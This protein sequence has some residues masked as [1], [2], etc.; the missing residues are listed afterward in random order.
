MIKF[1]KYGLHSIMKLMLSTQKIIL[2]AKSLFSSAS[3]LPGDEV[4]DSLFPQLFVID[5]SGVSV[6]IGSQSLG[7]SVVTVAFKQD[8]WVKLK[9]FFTRDVFLDLGW[10]L[11]EE[12][13]Q[14]I[15]VVSGNLPG[16]ISQ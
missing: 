2:V 1:I 15:S 9:L 13:E 6:F 11:G 3:L 8:A 16:S 7:S 12:P 10:T 5:S 14:F 4:T